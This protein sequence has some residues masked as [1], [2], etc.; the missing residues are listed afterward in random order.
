M[1]VQRI[2]ASA[3]GSVGE[4][5]QFVIDRLVDVPAVVKDSVALMVSELSTNALVHAGGG[6]AIVVDRADDAV[7]VSV[8]DRGNGT[9]ALQSP[10]SS[11]PHGR[12]LRIVD[13]LSDEWGISAA[14]DEETTVWFR[15]S[16]RSPETGPSGDRSVVSEVADSE[17]RDGQPEAH[18]ASSAGPSATSGGSPS[19][20]I[21]YRLHGPRR[22]SRVDSETTSGVG[23]TRQIR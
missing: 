10:G 16:L 3:D 21:S 6:F 1:T 7:F 11:E 13:A 23:R 19:R 12:G 8:S 14:S 18:P 9:P 2:F 17:A 15:L 20:T 22:R 5:R 4:A